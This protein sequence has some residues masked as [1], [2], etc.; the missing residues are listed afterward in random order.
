MKGLAITTQAYGVGF[1]LK[2]DGDGVVFPYPF[3]GFSPVC[4]PSASGRESVGD[5]MGG[6]P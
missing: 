5:T 6:T 3:G 4:H 2:I 1:S